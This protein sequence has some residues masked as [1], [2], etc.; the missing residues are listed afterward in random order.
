M[1]LEHIGF[2]DLG[3]RLHKAIDI[4]G[5]YEREVQITGRATGATTGEYGQYVQRT[6]EDPTIERRWQEYV[7]A[8]TP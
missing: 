8:E 5:Q 6:V 3:A 7:S 2:N 1:M 4:C